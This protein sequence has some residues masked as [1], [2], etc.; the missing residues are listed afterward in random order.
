MSSDSVMRPSAV[1]GEASPVHLFASVLVGTSYG[2]YSFK[3]QKRAAGR[4]TIGGL[5]PGGSS[6]YVMDAPLENSVF[7]VFFTLAAARN[8]IPCCRENKWK[9]LGIFKRGCCQHIHLGFDIFPPR[10]H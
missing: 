1:Q 5:S 8:Q 9:P 4:G 7:I 3:T 2:G 6:C 10:E